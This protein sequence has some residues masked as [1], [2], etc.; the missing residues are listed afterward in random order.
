VNT[1]KYSYPNRTVKWLAFL[2]LAALTAGGFWASVVTIGYWDTLWIGGSFYEDREVRSHLELES[3]SALELAALYQQKAWEET[4]NYRDE[5]RRLALEAALNPERTNFRY[6]VHRQDG[7][8]L[9][10]NVE[11][12]AL[13][14]AVY[15]TTM[16]EHILW[17]GLSDGNVLDAEWENYNMAYLGDAL[18][19]VPERDEDQLQITSGEETLL[20]SPREA[21]QAAQYGWSYYEEEWH[22][23]LNRDSRIQS[24]A[25]IIE[26]GL[27][28][29]LSIEDD[30]SYLELSYERFRERLPIIAS[31]ALVLDLMALTLLLFLCTV[32]GHAPDCETI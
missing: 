27:A 16:G 26:Y 10:G 29:P 2:L 6:Q 14:S 9:C 31:L 21:A 18:I 15:Q 20:F 12:G 1:M 32:A 28:Q 23:N 24:A 19:W 17:Q 8:L 11:D 5:Q 22:Y 3:Y 7:T 30:Y 4:L 13:D 25:L